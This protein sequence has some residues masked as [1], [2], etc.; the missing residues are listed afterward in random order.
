MKYAIA[1]L[2]LV[3][4]A[5]FLYKTLSAVSHR[6]SS[7]MPPDDGEAELY[8]AA[9]GTRGR[10]W[11][12]DVRLIRRIYRQAFRRAGSFADP[13]DADRNFYPQY[14]TF[15]E[16][17]AEYKKHIS[18]I[19]K[20]PRG[21]EGPRAGEI[22][23]QLLRAHD[24]HL[25]EER[26]KEA[27]AR[28][29]S[30]RPLRYCEISAMK[31]LVPAAVL[32]YTAAVLFEVGHTAD[33][34]A[35][36]T[37]DGEKDRMDL[38][39]L[40]E[41]A[42][43]AGLLRTLKGAS[44]RYLQSVCAEN[45]ISVRDADRAFQARNAW[46]GGRIQNA[47]DSLRR[48]DA[49]TADDRLLAI[50]PA[51]AVLA[52]TAVGYEDAADA[53]KFLYLEEIAR[54]AR[55][56][57][58]EE[59]VT[60]L[61]AASESARKGQDIAFF[62]LR[63]PAGYAAM[64]LYILTVLLIAAALPVC[65]PFLFGI[66][67]TAAYFAALPV[68]LSLTLSAAAAV[69]RR[70]VR[71]R[72]LPLKRPETFS[73]QKGLALITVSRLIGDEAELTEAYDH[74][75]TLK[76]ANPAPCFTYC[77]LLD[78]PP[79]GTEEPS[80]AERALL[81][82]A[83]ELYAALSDRD[84]YAVRIRRRTPSERGFGGWERKRGA[85]VE[86]NALLTGDSPHSGF[87]LQRGELPPAAKYNI[88]LDADTLINNAL[89]LTAAAEHPYNAAA[90]VIGLYTRP[91]LPSAERTRFSRLYADGGGTDGYNRYPADPNYDLFGRG[92]YTGKGLYRIGAFHRATGNAF[93]DNRILSHDFIE[94]AFAGCVTGGFYGIDEFPRDFS[95]FCTRRLRWQRGDIQLAPYLKRRIKDRS[96]RRMCNPIAPIDK[97][98]IFLNLFLP[99]APVAKFVICAVAL[100]SSPLLLFAAF[101][102]ELIAAAA[103]VRTIA[104][105]HKD[106]ARYLL[107]TVSD[108]VFLPVTA[109][110]A[111]W[112]YIKTMY[113]MLVRR[114]LLEWRVF[115]QAKG[116]LRFFPAAAAGAAFIGLNIWL[117]AGVAFYVLGALWLA[118]PLWN[119]YLSQSGRRPHKRDE[120]FEALLTD[121][122]VRTLRYFDAQSG[123]PVICDHY[124]ENVG[125]W[126]QRTSPTDIGMALTAYIAAAELGILSR[127]AAEARAAAVLAAIERA[128]KWKGHLYNWMTVDSAAAEPR[129]VSTVD[130]GNLLAALLAVQAYFPALSE[131]AGRLTDGTDMAALL[132]AERNLFYVGYD[133]SADEFDRSHY[134][135]LGSEAVTAYIVSIG[136]G[137]IPPECW[138][139]LSR[140]KVRYKGRSLLYS[141]SGGMFE[142]LMSAVYFEYPRSSGLGES[143]RA[144]VKAQR[145]YASE[146]SA[147]WGV[148][149]CQYTPAAS[150][151]SFR[152]RAFG[153]PYIAL[154]DV[155]DPPVTAP[156]A[157]LLAARFAPRHVYENVRRI[158]GAGGYGTYGFYEALSDAPV[159][160]YMSHHQGMILA[161]IC[162]CLK[163]G[164][165]PAV[166]RRSP[167]VRAAEICFQERIGGR[168][169]QR[170]RLP[171]LRPETCAEIPTGEYAYPPVVLLGDRLRTLVNRCGRGYAVW[172]GR[173]ITL[174]ASRSD[175]MYMRVTTAGGELD[176]VAD[177][178]RLSA[179]G[180]L[181]RAENRT[182]YTETEIL[183]AREAECRTVRIKNRTAAPQEVI[184]SAMVI[185]ALFR[186]DEYSGQL[187]S[188]FYIETTDCGRFVTAARTDG[189]SDIVVGLTGSGGEIGFFGN[190]GAYDNDEPP[191]FGL[192]LAPALGVTG[193]M[194][195]P[196]RGEGVFRL[197]LTAGVSEDDV[198][199]RLN[200]A[201]E[202]GDSALTAAKA[203]SRKLSPSAS[204]CAMAAAVLYGRS[205]MAEPYAGIDG[206]RPLLVHAYTDEAGLD[207]RLRDAA[208]CIRYALSFDLAVLY[209]ED[210]TTYK[211]TADF[212]VSRAEAFGLPQRL[213][214][215]FVAV[216]ESTDPE[217]AAALRNAA[218]PN[219]VPLPALA[220]AKRLRRRPTG[221]LNLRPAVPVF[222]GG[223]E[224]NGA[225][226]IDLSAGTPAPWSNVIADET[227]GTLMTESGAACSWH[228][229]S[230]RGKLTGQDNDPAAF[231]PSEYVIYGESGALWS[232]S[233]KPLPGRGAYYARHGF[234]YTEYLCDCNGMDISERHYIARG[235]KAKV[236]AVT[237]DNP[238]K[239]RRRID[240]M[241]CAEPVLGDSAR[242][243]SFVCGYAGGKMT[244]RA[245]GG[246]SVILACSEKPRSYAFH[247]EAYMRGGRILKN[248]ELSDCG[249]DPALACSVTVTVP[250]GGRYTLY[251]SL[252]AA[253]YDLSAA[254]K[255]FAEAGTF[256][257]SLSDIEAHTGSAEFDYLFKWL[258]YQTYCTDFY[259]RCCYGNAVGGYDFRSLLDGQAML[260]CDPPAVRR[261]ILDAAGHQF[262]SG[263]VQRL[264]FPPAVGLC[265]HEATDRLCLPLMTAAY[266]T[267]TGD[268][269]VLAE[270]IPYLTEPAPPADSRTV[271]AA[272]EPTK[273]SDS[274]LEHCKRALESVSATGAHGLVC[275]Y[276]DEDG[277]GARRDERHNAESV[278][279]TML[280]YYV[281]GRFSSILSDTDLKL[282]YAT[283]RKRLADALDAAWEEDRYVRQFGADGRAV[284]APFDAECALDLSVQALSALSG[285]GRP[286]RAETAVKTALSLVDF[287]AGIVKSMDPPFVVGRDTSGT[288]ALPPGVKDNGGQRTSEAVGYIRA[289]YALGQKE[290]AYKLVETIN[291]V[292]HG[293]T[294]GD[295]YRVEPYVLADD[296]G[297]GRYKGRG[298][299]TWYG[300]AASALYACLV[301]DL[302]GLHRRGKKVWLSPA[303]PAQF[304]EITIRL[305]YDCGCL[306]VIIDNTSA[307]GEWKTI[308]DGIAYNTNEISLTYSVAGK[309]VRLKRVP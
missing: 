55:K 284:G 269:T 45:G 231:A 155:P 271:F 135:L 93:P 131:T 126:A 53:T 235:K 68:S 222:R 37:A 128:P 142:Y 161:G 187:K 122:A 229:D 201:A 307:K 44:A 85:L 174:Y 90:G 228:L 3:A 152:Y 209:K 275:E 247:K 36:G 199:R 170:R 121:A 133:E 52:E 160:S 193:R 304:K 196:P 249:S 99:S 305:R 173:P 192:T 27:F 252:S 79:S 309:T 70:T 262:R 102:P 306:T 5:L 286:D 166:M 181:F 30:V 251:F 40:R 277:D 54:R 39:L 301:E 221:R 264:W 239:C 22:V 290:A 288:A 200:A 186:T 49:C 69:V 77:L 80:E 242:H 258:P 66:W 12:A 95:A 114:R 163:D 246:L 89:W 110:Y 254:E 65:L 153:V 117:N 291:P 267:Y 32:E 149:E 81:R 202:E 17:L 237:F 60:A 148:S 203:L 98:H 185:P 261:R 14:Y 295:N 63:P 64:R 259:G 302:L 157:T 101:A 150:D 15:T 188:T 127:D 16:A 300:G 195:L 139:A 72:Y 76:Y 1:A 294:D 244:A 120:A 182:V 124:A 176:P 165:I 67:G 24:G 91:S 280:L 13:L 50:S 7:A 116:K 48:A 23:L 82:R 238:L 103:S 179:E 35:K 233:K 272:A 289:L 42:Y 94:G 75:Q 106:A 297:A 105:G 268:F 168:G 46:T 175:G 156:Y 31:A 218:V 137:K 10:A 213:N 115:A 6:L 104:L 78:L 278:R 260:Y 308:V 59:T 73:G 107:R 61:A 216:N 4:A 220:A 132:D 146:P 29:N 47:V 123:F 83:G 100:L 214:G 208:D 184:L 96:G 11:P 253:E 57:R 266:V 287:K 279:A 198:G 167:A 281:L 2:I 172:G 169:E 298:G 113:R 223:F 292:R 236:I 9:R 19:K 88:A 219:N 56:K 283:W 226:L 143:V 158:I 189:R 178:V 109:A 62:L 144:A 141:W 84:R 207:D 38:S 245:S 270:R 51:A 197:Y 8:A 129:Y 171:A 227:F 232:A 43:L 248:S 282:R 234:G 97:W 183:S 26:F 71:R 255:D 20:L 190:R 145:L 118:A 257:A 21:K 225:Y 265:A 240:V 274:V 180:C 28:V 177:A 243:T 204:A 191:A 215:R 162:N 151:G 134:D 41:T 210:K 33:L 250:A 140:K 92:N 285:A 86:L 206:S 205:Y 147:I 34:Y 263:D 293:K 112:M 194:Q 299:R 159:P 74:I 125:L 256:Y 25:T 138:Y 119:T 18:A 136:L 108:I 217:I 111:L 211:E 303:P 154:S 296:V 164:A 212:I 276:P 87:L 273:K 230:R 58:T 241:F 224:R 130:S